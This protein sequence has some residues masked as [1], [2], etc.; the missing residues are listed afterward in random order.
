MG[1]CVE[2]SL[3]FS[4]M[5]IDCPSVTKCC[6][7]IDLKNG[8]IALGLLTLVGSVIGFISGFFSLVYYSHHVKDDGHTFAQYIS[9]VILVVISFLY[10]GASSILLY[11]IKKNEPHLLKFW[12]VLSIITLILDCGKIIL[13]VVYMGLPDDAK[14]CDDGPCD[15]SKLVYYNLIVALTGL[16]I[17]IYFLISVVS[18]RNQLTE[19]V[20]SQGHA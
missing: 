12:I 5:G 4:R 10:I 18:F 14:P 15:Y 17:G 1:S 13:S 2:T 20:K 3:D 7:C 19:Q 8:T 6:C 11:G 9:V 16:L